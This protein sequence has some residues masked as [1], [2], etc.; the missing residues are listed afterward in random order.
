MDEKPKQQET[1]AAAKR[2]SDQRREAMYGGPRGGLLT[3]EWAQ[4]QWLRNHF[5][6]TA[7]DSTGRRRFIFQGELVGRSLEEAIDARILAEVNRHGKEMKNLLRQELPH[8][9]ET[10]SAP[11]KLTAEEEHVMFHLSMGRRATQDVMG[12]VLIDGKKVAQR[13][14]MVALEQRGFVRAV[15][16]RD[17]LALAWESTPKGQ[18]WKKS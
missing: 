9:E 18:Q 5:V 8:V 1:D 14:T 10:Q 16:V 6:P 13:A 11:V 17:G 3:R 15:E 2:L 4:L 12:N 7:P